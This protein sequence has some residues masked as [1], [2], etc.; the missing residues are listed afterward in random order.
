MATARF[1]N[2]EFIFNKSEMSSE[3]VGGATVEMREVAARIV[4]GF[5]GRRFLIW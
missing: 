3:F 1:D 5:G 2:V 4:V